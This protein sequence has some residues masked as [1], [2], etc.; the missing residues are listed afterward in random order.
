MYSVCVWYMHV[1]EAGNPNRLAMQAAAPLQNETLLSQKKK[2]QAA[3]AFR[4]RLT[5]RRF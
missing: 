4:N 3:L 1:L 5:Y 2:Y